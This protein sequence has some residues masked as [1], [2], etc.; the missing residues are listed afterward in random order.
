MHR[1]LQEKKNYLAA[2]WMRT[3]FCHLHSSLETKKCTLSEMGIGYDLFKVHSNG[4][5]GT[6]GSIFY[7]FWP[8]RM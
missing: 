1:S 4:I 6:L 5:H 2:R 8:C 3:R 7:I